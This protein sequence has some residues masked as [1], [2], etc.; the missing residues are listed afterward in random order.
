M[1]CREG[2]GA[3]LEVQG[4][5][6]VAK[7]AGQAGKF[8]L[9]NSGSGPGPGGGGA[10][11]S[12]GWGAQPQGAASS[13]RQQETTREADSSSSQNL[14]PS[15]QPT[16]PPRPLDT[17][18]H[19]DGVDVIAQEAGS[20][21][22]NGCCECVGLSLTGPGRARTAPPP[23]TGTVNESKWALGLERVGADRIGSLQF[24]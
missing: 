16:P 23:R 6:R 20:S 9:A 3:C 15:T 10:A 12:I 21:S 19:V 13:T 18:T 24:W 8:G 2:G 14:K 4:L 5:G 11:Q 7:G 1:I 22:L 17:A